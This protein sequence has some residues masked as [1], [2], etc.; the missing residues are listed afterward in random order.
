M[1]RNGAPTKEAAPPV[2][3]A[4]PNDPQPIRPGMIMY[5]REAKF[6]P[7]G[8]KHTAI[9][10]KGHGFGIFL[11]HCPQLAPPP[12]LQ[13]VKY[14]ISNIGYAGFDEIQELMGVEF[15]TQLV[16][17]MEEKYAKLLGFPNDAPSSVSQDPLGLVA[18]NGAPLLSTVK[19]PEPN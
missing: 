14:M 15:T 5:Y 16:K 11:G 12:S 10:F 9:R 18:P 6:S 1:D 3:P 2:A 8:K 19:P 13:L 17:K 7:R 4:G